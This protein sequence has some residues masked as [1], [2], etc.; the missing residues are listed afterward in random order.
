MTAPLCPTND[1]KQVHFS[2]DA[3][4]L[5]VIEEGLAGPT[6]CCSRCQARTKAGDFRAQAAKDAP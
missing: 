4:G 6:C 5:D 1:R 2:R 3:Q